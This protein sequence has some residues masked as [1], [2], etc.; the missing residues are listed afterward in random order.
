MYLRYSD[1][2]SNYNPVILCEISSSIYL[3]FKFYFFIYYTPT[4]QS[5]SNL[6][7]LPDKFLLCVLSKEKKKSRLL[8][9]STEHSLTIRLG[10][11]LISQLDMTTQ[12][13]EKGPTRT[14]S[15]TTLWSIY[16]KD[17]VQTHRVSVFV[18]C[19]CEAQWELFSWFCGPL[20]SSIP[21][22]P[23]ILPCSLQ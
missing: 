14:P 15:Y 13:K 11:N 20:V 1:V 19:F 12:Q 21:P 6:P 16:V 7:S 9:I 22:D 8:R 23:T 2:K 17:L 4:S 18:N 10:T 3:F 5:L